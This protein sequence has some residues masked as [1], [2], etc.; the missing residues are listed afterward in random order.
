VPIVLVK[1][2]RRA[3]KQLATTPWAGVSLTANPRGR[4]RKLP[5]LR[6]RY[7]LFYEVDEAAGEVWV[8]RVWHM[9]RGQKPNLQATR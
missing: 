2:F 6:A 5:L 8:L 3:K 9:S 7:F 1:E 4:R